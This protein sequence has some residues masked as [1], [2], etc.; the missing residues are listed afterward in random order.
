MVHTTFAY[1]VPYA[2][3]DQDM[4]KGCVV[5]FGG[6]VSPC[7]ILAFFIEEESVCYS[8]FIITAERSQLLSIFIDVL[9][10]IWS[11][12]GAVI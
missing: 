11:N 3:A 9:E 7:P 2:S 5:F 8:E 4:V 12:Y 1:L 6:R 10:P